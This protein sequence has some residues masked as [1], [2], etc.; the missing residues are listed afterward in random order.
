MRGRIIFFKEGGNVVKFAR[1]V[2]TIW[3]AGVR[4]DSCLFPGS[5]GVDSSYYLINNN[6]DSCTITCILL[7]TMT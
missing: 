2:L 5:G 7:I 6:N 1:W 4:S 3:T